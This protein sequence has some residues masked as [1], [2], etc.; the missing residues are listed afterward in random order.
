MGN[1]L[2]LTIIINKLYTFFDYYK[3]NKL[4]LTGDFFYKNQTK[5]LIDWFF[6]GIMILLRNARILI[7]GCHDG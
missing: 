4:K 1:C 6:N 3:Q 7:R 2:P 5:I